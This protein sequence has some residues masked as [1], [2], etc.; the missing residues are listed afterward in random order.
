M[1]PRARAGQ[2]RFAPGALDVTAARA[3]VVQALGAH[4]APADAAFIE[5]QLNVLPTPHPRPNCLALRPDRSSARPADQLD[6]DRLPR[7]RMVP[8][9]VGP[10]GDTP[11]VV[12]DVSGLM[13]PFGDKVYVRYGDPVIVPTIGE[14]KPEDLARQNAVRAP[15]VG[16]YAMLPKAGKCVPGRT[17]G[18]RAKATQACVGDARGR[19]A[20]CDRG[21]RQARAVAAH[22][23]RDE[24]AGDGDAQRRPDGDE[25]GHL[26]SL[27]LNART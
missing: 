11:D 27:R 21:V 16:A 8:V 1:T 18:V 5:Q 26:P 6:R 4:F 3:A 25:D 7:E 20:T 10:H 17:I 15:R 13:A 14:V 23:P 22:E 2:W 12:A 19:Q 9:R 24:G